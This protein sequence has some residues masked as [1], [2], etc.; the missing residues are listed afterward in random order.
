MRFPRI[1]T[2]EQTDDVP[3]RRLL[4]RTSLHQQLLALNTG[5]KRC[6]VKTIINASRRSQLVEARYV[7]QAAHIAGDVR[8]PSLRR[9]LS[10]V[11]TA[12]LVAEAESALVALSAHLQQEDPCPSVKPSQT[13]CLLQAMQRVMTHLQPDDTVRTAS[14]AEGSDDA[15]LPGR[16][17][18]LAVAVPMPRRNRPSLCKPSVMRAT[19][20]TQPLDVT[21]P[22]A[23]VSSATA[24]F[25]PEGWR[26]CPDIPGALVR[27]SQ[28]DASEEAVEAV[29]ASTAFEAPAAAALEPVVEAPKNEGGEPKDAPV[30]APEE[31]SKE[32]ASSWE[33]PRE[34][35]LRQAPLSAEEERA[36]R[37]KLQGRLRAARFEAAARVAEND[38]LR[39]LLLSPR[40][41]DVLPRRHSARA[42]AWRAG[43]QGGSQPSSQPSSPHAIP[44][45]PPTPP[46]AEEAETANAE[47]AEA[48]T[49]EC[50][51]AGAEA[52]G[53]VVAEEEEA[54]A[55]TAAKEAATELEACD[56]VGHMEVAASFA[57]SRSR[58]LPKGRRGTVLRR[59]FVGACHSA[60][61]E[62]GAAEPAPPAAPARS[63]LMCAIEQRRDVAE[64]RAAVTTYVDPRLARQERLLAEK[65]G[66]AAGGGPSAPLALAIEKR[67]E[68][69]EAQMRALDE[70]VA[71]LLHSPRAAREAELA[72][73]RTKRFNQRHAKTKRV[74]GGG[75]S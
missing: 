40:Q 21:G 16:E 69:V 9:Q 11:A 72:A 51:G 37:E 28:V 59:D 26:P 17:D 63:Q 60:P 35:A 4:G 20:C 57:A 67:R 25:A 22:M 46:G 73:G 12:V 50:K 18:S 44:A 7:A 43:Q 58:P 10:E 27:V 65:A 38:E 19:T 34:D 71:V 29:A 66:M 47:A 55:E 70:G 62:G 56:T 39:Q 15:W 31:A 61:G 3:S 5:P 13:S 49:A 2:L 53:V 6:S 48:E 75:E 14:I 54:A 68:A 64:A 23:S 41:E 30:E 42:A 45:V 52:A 32:E 1:G 74:A 24:C 36:W 33:W 8:K